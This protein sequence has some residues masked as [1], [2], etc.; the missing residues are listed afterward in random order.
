MLPETGAEATLEGQ[1]ASTAWPW[2]EWGG[3][4][5]RGLRVG[6]WVGLVG[7][8]GLLTSWAVGLQAAGLFG[9]W[10]G[11]EVELG[12]GEVLGEVGP[13]IHLLMQ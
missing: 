13:T 9:G 1:P 6:C 5:K 7:L 4:G 11:G 2:S 8:V 12:R 3:S 10:E